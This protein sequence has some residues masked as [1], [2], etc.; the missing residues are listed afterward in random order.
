MTARPSSSTGSKSPGAS[1][2]RGE[3]TGAPRTRGPRR[4]LIALFFFL[5]AI[6]LYANTMGNGY[7]VDDT[8]FIT[9]N[10]Y[11]KNGIR[12]IPDIFSHDSFEGYFNEKKSLVSGGRYRPLSIATFAIEHQVAGENPALGHAVNL[13]LYGL[14]GALLYLLLIRL[15]PPDGKVRWWATAPFLI[16]LLFM[17]HPLHT[18]VVANIK[19]RDEILALLFGIA[20][21]HAFLTTCERP[22]A[23]GLLLLA[24]G[25]L[26]Y[27][28]GLLSKETLIPFLVV[29]PLGIWFF[30]RVDPRRLGIVLGAMA[31]PL[32]AYF[33]IR[34][35]FAGPMKIVRT[36]D[37]LNDPFTYATLEQRVATIFKT[38]GIYLRLF[39][40]PHPLTS[41][42]YYNHVPLAHLGDPSSFLPALITL[43]LAAYAV[44]GMRGRNPIAYGILFFAI[45]FSIVSNLLFS[46]GT[47]MAERFLYIP[48]L[49]LAIAAVLGVEALS[50]RLVGRNGPRVAA[51]FLILI[52]AAYS[53]KTV[54]R[55]PAWKDNYTLFTTDIKVSPNSAKI[56]AAVASILEEEANKKKDPA[57]HQALIEQAIRHFRRAIQIYPEHSLAWFGLG[58]LLAAQGNEH[59]KEAIQ[60]YRHVVAL[61][62]DKAVAFRNI[63][64]TADK[65]GDFET[66]LEGI[67]SY[68]RL[69]P[70]DIEAG[71]LEASYLNKSG[72]VGEAIRV[73]EEV[74][75]ANPRN[76]QLWSDM[77][78]FFANTA[79]DYGKAVEYLDRAI[80][81]DSTK[82]GTYENL[83]YAQILN[84]QPRA[85]V[86]TLEKGVARF[87]ETQLLEWNL[88]AAWDALGERQKS[89]RAISRSKELGGPW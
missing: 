83:G 85:A 89:E 78:L 42:Y 59:A 45:T 36:G 86:Q 35:I 9:D 47:T 66:A 72:R 67:R 3:P 12:G 20:T 79:H 43:G 52:C 15:L 37:L 29:I 58:N 41:D 71:L 80:Q 63:A 27:F 24:A 26:F 48:S 84:K 17:T 76:A 60:C 38:V 19:S 54:S 75:R 18:E 34:G 69:R 44:A 61:E 53:V 55:N 7:A 73:R 14:T 25:A 70:A 46:I 77:G 50:G 88:G 10:A 56:Q 40:V 49:G 11:T 62:P 64:L 57:L 82:V 81:L 23:R 21:F 16:T 31:L 22:G 2:N 1:R 39:L 68:R 51:G 33:V 6:P 8:M 30:R 5:L 87:G 32:A 28:L 13:A 4:S 74:A 65:I